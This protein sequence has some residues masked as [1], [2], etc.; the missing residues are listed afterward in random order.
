M[1]P[2]SELPSRRAKKRRLQ[3]GLLGLLAVPLVVSLLLGRYSAILRD[4]WSSQML[5]RQG[6]EIR[7]NDAGFAMEVFFGNRVNL[8]DRRLL[9]EIANLD[10]VVHVEFAAT[11]VDAASLRE[12]RKLPVLESLTFFNTG[13]SDSMIESV[14]VMRNLRRVSLIGED[15][16]D[17]GLCHLS[18]L[19]CLSYL[20]LSGSQVRSGDLQV[21][22][23]CRS[24][25]YLYLTGC[26][27]VDDNAI[28]YI[29]DM[30]DLK[31]VEIV[32]TAFTPEGGRSLDAIMAPDC[33]VQ[34]VLCT[35]SESESTMGLTS[36]SGRQE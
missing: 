30:E 5:E 21:L 22:S 7:R 31:V 29:R 33:F 10:H 9:K 17:V 2:C 18:D 15:I 14:A 11:E 1:T 32:G 8:R 26:Q 12:L 24:L 13:I 3:F 28:P 25:K 27:S 23:K 4:R 19:P 36:G 16:S 35:P 6:A 34:G 20:S